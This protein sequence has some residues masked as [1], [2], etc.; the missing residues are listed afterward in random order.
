MVARWQNRL[1]RPQKVVA[2]GCHLNRPVADLVEKG[3]FRFDAV[4]TFY[5]TKPPRTHGWVT[6]GAAVK[7]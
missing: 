3:G 1:N 5:A 4:R 2:C 7:A 6:I